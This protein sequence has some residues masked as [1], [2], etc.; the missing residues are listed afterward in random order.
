M[1]SSVASATP[2]LPDSVDA[3]ANCFLRNSCAALRAVRWDLLLP[4]GCLIAHF[5]LATKTFSFSL[6]H[7]SSLAAISALT[8]ED[9]AL[10]F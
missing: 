2:K 4:D 8:V 6:I 1:V 9:E 10:G 7:R 5:A 3:L